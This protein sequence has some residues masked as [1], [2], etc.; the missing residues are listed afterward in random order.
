MI[1]KSVNTIQE[2]IVSDY[3]E[4]IDINKYVINGN[5]VHLTFRGQAK[6]EIPNNVI[7]LSGIPQN[8]VTDVCL[9][10]LSTDKYASVD[11]E[12]K[13]SYFSNTALKIGGTTSAGKWVHISC[14]YIKA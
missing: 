10:T 2:M 8:A 3:F 5:V 11:K 1:P 7:I 13:W 6:R 9:F 4:N 12:I 14:T